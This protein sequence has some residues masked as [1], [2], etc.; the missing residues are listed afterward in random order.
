MGP[1]GVAQVVV[2]AFPFSNLGGSKLRPAIVLADSGRGDWLLCQVTSN[3]LAD[4]KAVEIGMEDF[5][6]GALPLRSFV[7]PG[8]LFTADASLIRAI[9]ARLQPAS[10]QRIV[11][12]VI[13][14]IRSGGSVESR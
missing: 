3:P 9:A 13:Q 6:E 4:L 14:H 11:S 5:L 2:V 8:K 7:R 10:H 1:I 12:A